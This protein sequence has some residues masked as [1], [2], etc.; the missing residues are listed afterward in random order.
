[1]KLNFFQFFCILLAGYPSIQLTITNKISSETFAAIVALTSSGG[2]KRKKS[3]KKG[4]KK[5]L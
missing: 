4:K 1:M 2:G 5:V 3:K